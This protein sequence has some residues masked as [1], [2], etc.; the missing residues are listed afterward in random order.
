MAV[1]G[2]GS[3]RPLQGSVAV[4][5]GA[6]RG[7]GRA[8]ALDL[9]AAGAR[10][11]VNDLGATPVTTGTKDEAAESVAREIRELGGDAFCVYE[12]VATM[13]GGKRIIDAAMDHFG[14][15]DTLVCNAGI[16][17]P[18]SIFDL[19]E[20]DWDEVIET[21][22]KGHFSMMQ[23]AARIMRDQA[24]GSIVTMT[25]SGGLEGSPKQ[26]NYAASKEG[27]VGL[28]RSVALAL[29]PYATCNAVSPSA[30]TRM[31]A[32]MRPGHDPGSAEDVAPLVTFLAG[33]DARHITGQVIGVAG[34]RVS[35]FPQPRPIRSMFTDGTWTADR[36]AERWE[37]N[38]G[39]ERLV[40][41]E[42]MVGKV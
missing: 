29:A 41:W 7:I 23:P 33:P 2:R 19:T 9:A 22:L 4:V 13:Q 12:T 24:S 31:L 6:G 21:N 17:R 25:S 27:I 40:R 32:L 26:P 5:T 20:Q 30:S 34:N 16:L 35:I 8:I 14:R 1:A 28:M 3:E 39:G 10:I 42:R 11:I 37:A 36:I 18:A 15:L 38:L